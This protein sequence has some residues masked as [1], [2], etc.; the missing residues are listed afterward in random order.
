MTSMPCSAKWP[1]GAD[2][3][4]HQQLRRVDG[5]AGKD[6]FPRRP[7]L[8]FSLSRPVDHSDGT[9]ALDDESGCKSIS[10]DPEIAPRCDRNEIHARDTG[11]H[12]T[13][14]GRAIGA[15]ES[16]LLAAVDIPGEG[17]ARLDAG[18]NEGIV[19]RIAG[20]CRR[21]AE[22]TVRTVPVVAT[23][24]VTFG[25]PEVRQHLCEGPAPAA[26]LCPAVVVARVAANV[27]HAVDRR[28]AAQNPPPGMVDPPVVEVWLLFRRVTPVEPRAADGTG[29]CARHVHAPVTVGGAGL[30]EKDPNVRILAQAVRQNG[31]RRT[32]ADDDVV[33]HR[34]GRHLSNR[35]KSRASASYQLPWPR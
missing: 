23:F 24:V 20:P 15:S 8:G 19:E 32:G 27:H 16:F 5:P 2:S 12:A 31:A 30:Q 3:R 28:G 22:R 10:D 4:E 7:C 17:I 11:P 6:D 13:W 34:H 1:A 26:L 29:E 35:R 18:L 9:P 14:R 21:N 33:P 25:A